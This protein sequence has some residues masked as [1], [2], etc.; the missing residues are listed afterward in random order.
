[1][2]GSFALAPV[3]LDRFKAVNDR[4]GHEA[5]STTGVGQPPAPLVLHEVPWDISASTGV[6]FYPRDGQDAEGPLRAADAAMYAVK[7]SGRGGVGY[8]GSELPR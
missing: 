7:Q 6:A 8:S 3:E 2:G 1:M 5:A 4:F